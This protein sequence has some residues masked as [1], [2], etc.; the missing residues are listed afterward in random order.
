MTV[1]WQKGLH[2]HILATGGKYEVFSLK[3]Q[4]YFFFSKDRSF[5]PE[6]CKLFWMPLLPCAQQTRS[7][8]CWPL[9]LPCVHKLEN[10]DRLT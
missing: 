1:D 6:V 9:I 4:D 2:L 7:F 3:S 8:M 10:A 5:S